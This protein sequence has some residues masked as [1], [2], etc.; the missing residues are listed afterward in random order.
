HL[1]Y[2]V[3]VLNQKGLSG[4][5]RHRCA[6]IINVIREERHATTP[7]R[8][9]HFHATLQEDA[10]TLSRVRESIWG[11]CVKDIAPLSV[12]R[13]NRILDVIE[14]RLTVVRIKLVVTD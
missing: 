1:R 2:D 3:S 12:L 5:H 14:H 13:W 9:T 11:I 10:A 6:L 7:G 8:L 4:P